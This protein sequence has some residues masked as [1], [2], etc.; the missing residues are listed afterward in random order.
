MPWTVLGR[1][2]GRCAALTCRD[3]RE[4]YCCRAFRKIAMHRDDMLSRA[5]YP[6][7][8]VSTMDQAGGPTRQRSR[9]AHQRRDISSGACSKVL[10]PA[11]H[12]SGNSKCCSGNAT[13]GA[14]GC[15]TP[16][17]PSLSHTSWL[18]AAG[19]RLKSYR[20]I[21]RRSDRVVPQSQ[22]KAGQQKTLHLHPEVASKPNLMCKSVR[23]LAL[24]TR[25]SQV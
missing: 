13:G 16:P 24:Y 19:K 1:V 22:G 12:Y 7:Q 10:I 14:A 23:T 20:T 8:R 5:R 21:A 4:C 15:K 6:A 11:Q 17:R 9:S 3:V 2:V 25:H 18:L